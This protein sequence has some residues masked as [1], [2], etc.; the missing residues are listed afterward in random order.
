MH[1]CDSVCILMAE[2]S[3]CNRHLMTHSLKIT[4]YSF[5][6]K[7]ADPCFSVLNS[8]Q[9]NQRRD[10]EKGT[11]MGFLRLFYKIFT[12]VYI[13]KSC[14][15]ETWEWGMAENIWEPCR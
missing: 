15:H 2:L 3:S 8:K 10:L 13:I 1:V 5:T 9:N 12:Y 7:F 14:F 11:E 4:L 6:G